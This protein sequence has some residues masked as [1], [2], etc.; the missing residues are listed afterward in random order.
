MNNPN[1]HSGSARAAVMAASLGL[2]LF[3]AGWALFG[4]ATVRAQ[5]KPATKLDAAAI[6]SDLDDIERLRVI[7]PLKLQPDQMDKLITAL[8]SAQADYDKKVNTLGTTIFGSSG[9]EIHNVRA[10]AL[11]GAEIPKEFDDK[12]KKL[13]SDFLKQR[14]DLNIENIKR[15]AAVCRIALTDKQ[16]AVATKMERDEY[17]KNH[18]DAKSVTDVQLFNLYCVD[19]FISNPRVVAQLK[20]ARAAAK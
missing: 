4:G 16:I 17:T 20:D 13:Q 7:N 5:D 10:K 1:L 15:V 18:S 2:V 12:I 19:V 8:T 9:A 3:L 11:S 14:D 6:V